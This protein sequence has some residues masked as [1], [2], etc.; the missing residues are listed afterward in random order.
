MTRFAWLQTRTQTLVVAAGLLV[1]AVASVVT[2]VHLSS[3]Y[4][5]LVA[6]CHAQG[7]C[8]LATGHFLA[9]YEFI[10][11]AFDMLVLLVPALVGVFW[12]APLIARE[13]DTGTYRLAWTQSVS[14]SRWV[15]TKLAVGGLAA[16][17]VGA[18][19]MLTVTWWFR[20]LDRVGANQYDLF[21]RRDIA[22]V[23]Y[24]VFAFAL[25]AL[26]GALLRRPLPAMAT[27]LIAFVAVRIAMTVW[28]RPHLLPS[29]R[30]TVPLLRSGQ[31]GFMSNGGSD[32]TIVAQGSA[33]AN[34][35]TLS[36]QIVTQSGHPATS[37]E[38]SA[39]VHQYCPQ[40]IVPPP[41]GGGGARVADPGVFR[42]CGN[43]AARTYHIVVTYQPASH[44]WGLQ[45]LESAIYLVLA[46]G[47]ALGCFW[48]VTRRAS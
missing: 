14:R 17:A 5:S 27:T 34:A 31:F 33:P 3:L 8:D 1:V 28:V 23:A 46:L 11:Q 43:L 22:P 15:A 44:Y 32:V 42:A 19:F 12:G 29:M 36:S 24:T 9:Q 48:W 47:A 40:V 20:G 38:L 21:D 2:G 7:D 41:S 25:G 39:F 35:W 45:W 18:V 30:T 13:M 10:Q 6:P 26:L 37:G 4:S 16:A